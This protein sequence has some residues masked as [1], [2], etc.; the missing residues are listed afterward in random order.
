MFANTAAL[1]RMMHRAIPSIRFPQ[2][3]KVSQEPMLS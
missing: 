2:A 3:L 1:A